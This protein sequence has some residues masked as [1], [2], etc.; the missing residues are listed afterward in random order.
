MRSCTVSSWFGRGKAVTLD[1]EELWLGSMN[2][3]EERLTDGTVW[4]TVEGESEC[5]PTAQEFGDPEGL[6]SGTGFRRRKGVEEGT[7]VQGP[8]WARKRTKQ[9]IKPSS[10]QA[11]QRESPHSGDPADG[12]HLMSATHSPRLSRSTAYM[13]PSHGDKNRASWLLMALIETVLKAALSKFT[14][15]RHQSF[16]NLELRAPSTEPRPLRRKQRYTRC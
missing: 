11:N 14:P 10:L 2:V 6:A 16:L 9:A 3:G 4:W 1:E 5:L 8:S 7:N 13:W 12:A 15:V